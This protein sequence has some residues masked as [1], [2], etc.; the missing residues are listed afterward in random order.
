M[1]YFKGEFLHAEDFQCEQQ[2]YIN[3]RIRHNQYLH[4]PGIVTGLTA[5]PGTG[6]VTIK[7]GIAIDKNGQEIILDVDYDVTS[8]ASGMIIGIK[9]KEGEDPASDNKDTT[10]PG[11]KRILESY[12]VTTNNDPDA[13]PL[14]KVKDATTTPV[15][16][17]TAYKL[18]YSGPAVM[19]D[20]TIQGNLTVQGE[21]TVVKTD[22]MQGNVVLGDNDSDQTTIEGILLSGHSSGK[23]QIGSSINM[24]AN[25]ELAFQDNG[26]IRSLD[27]NHRILFRRSEN[28][29]E[30]REFGD[31]IFSPGATAGVETAKVVMQ[32]NGNMGIGTTTPDRSLTVANATGANYMNVKDGTHEILMGVD[33]N[34]GILSVMSNHDLILRAGSNSEKMR[35]TAGGK[36]GI[37]ITTPSSMLEVAGTIKSPMWNITQLFNNEAGAAPKSKQFTSGGGTLLIFASGSGW[38]PDVARQIGMDIKIDNILKGSA[39]SFTNEINSH[40]TFSANFLVVT[41][42]SAGTHTLALTTIAGTST[43]YNDFFSATILEL[44]FDPPS[45]AYVNAY[46]TY[47]NAGDYTKSFIFK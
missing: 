14:A 30:L 16:L 27:N 35:I 41:G 1:N 46:V 37:G 28:K 10:F 34:G 6:K 2:Y 11:K 29:L 12:E 4:T 39:K 40:K 9:Y 5:L 7:S 24:V 43:D 3:K 36:V 19:G 26:Q 38:S 31:L 47:F 44:P 32:G 42:I 25:G 22:K 15:T 17:D 13:V 45:L 23:L 21:T 8:V 20:L 33:G 18:A